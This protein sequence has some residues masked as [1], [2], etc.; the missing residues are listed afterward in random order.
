VT[1]LFILRVVI[2][3]TLTSVLLISYFIH[4]TIYSKKENRLLHI[5]SHL[6]QINFTKESHKFLQ[7]QETLKKISSLE[8][9]LINKNK[10]E[11]DHKKKFFFVESFDSKSDKNFLTLFYWSELNPDFYIQIKSKSDTMI[12]VSNLLITII[13]IIGILAISLIVYSS[14]FYKNGM[15]PIH[16]LNTTLKSINEKSIRQI[17]KDRLP[18]EFHLLAD[19][20][21]NLF[22]RIDNFMKYQNELFIGTAH[23]LKTPLSVIK[24]KNQVLL[25]KERNIEEYKT[26]LK[27]NIEKVDEMNNA[28]SSVLSVGRQ[29]SAQFEDPV[30]VDIIEILKQKGA[31]FQVLANSQNKILIMDIS[32]KSYMIEIQQTLFIQMIQNLLQNS[33][34]FTEK[35]KKIILK[36]YPVFSQGNIKKIQALK[37]EIIDEGIGIDESTDYFAPFK[38]TGNKSG[39]GLG[40]FLVKSASDTMGANISIKNRKDGISG[41]IASF[42]I[43]NKIISLLPDKIDKK[44][45]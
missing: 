12:M 45:E 13:V 6:E 42:E 18:K 28:V 29:E 2:A 17:S 3:L 14:V 7:M 1:N 26:A 22:N 24:L 15:K 41:T 33:L 43:K 39:T 4:T 44:I 25:L 21:N 23:E 30:S 31:D 16:I 11:F 34:K 27:L 5:A 32:P 8:I 40:L 10:L 36:S 20:L 38:R 37:I 35:N 9:E 19:T